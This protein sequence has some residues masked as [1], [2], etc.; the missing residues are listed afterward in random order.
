MVVYFLCYE[1]I[2][3]IFNSLLMRFGFFLS[4]PLSYP[5]C[6]LHVCMYVFHQTKG[7]LMLNKRQHLQR[8]NATFSVMNSFC[9]KIKMACVNKIIR[10]TSTSDLYICAAFMETDFSLFL[11][12]THVL[13]ACSRHHINYRKRDTETDKG[14]LI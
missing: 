4:H 6:L 12:H 7:F 9:E 5:F 14:V 3:N 1:M 2:L 8:K 10:I 11:T 13:A